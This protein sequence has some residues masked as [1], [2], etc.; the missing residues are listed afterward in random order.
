MDNFTTKHS[1]LFSTKNSKSHNL[2]Q[3]IKE[4]CIRLLG[5][6]CTC[7]NS[8]KL[9]SNLQTQEGRQAAYKHVSTQ[10]HTQKERER[11][12]TSIWVSYKVLKSASTISQ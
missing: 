3:H 7:T 8:S 9:S 11:K 4:D 2:A 12:T 5:H 6:S 10:T 1:G